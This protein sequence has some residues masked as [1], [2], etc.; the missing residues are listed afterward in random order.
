MSKPRPRWNRALRLFTSTPGAPDHDDTLEWVHA[1]SLFQSLADPERFAL[2]AVRAVGAPGIPSDAGTGKDHTLVVVREFRRVPLGASNLGLLTL[3]ARP[4]A[5]ASLLAAL[6]LWVERALSCY[7]PT[8]LL[9]AHSL[10]HPRL[11]TLIAGVNECRALAIPDATA[12]S[13][14]LLLPEL[15]GFLAE[16]PEWWAYRPDLPPTRSRPPSLRMRCSA[17]GSIGEGSFDESP[18][19]RER[20]RAKTRTR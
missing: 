6:G 14:D 16:A 2:Y 10:E 15:R 4:G 17:E 7:Q 20:P 5:T 8:Y 9:L 3:V 19:E 13:V 11:A 1:R 12:F 18:H